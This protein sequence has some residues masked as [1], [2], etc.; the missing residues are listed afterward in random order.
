ML[1]EEL[2]RQLARQ[3]ELPGQAGVSGSKRNEERAM[4]RFSLDAS[5]VWGGGSGGYTTL[6]HNVLLMDW[7]NESSTEKMIQ[8]SRT[9]GILPECP[10][11]WVER[12]GT[13][14]QISAPCTVHRSFMCQLGG[15]NGWMDDA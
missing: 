10:E 14:L 8:C 3:G 5:R 4:P 2:R 1:P 12:V 6:N 11:G 9:T 13:G 7:F 15:V